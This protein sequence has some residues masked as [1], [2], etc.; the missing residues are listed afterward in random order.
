MKEKRS[1]L[2]P[3]VPIIIQFCKFR[4]GSE[5]N[6]RQKWP[7]SYPSQDHAKCHEVK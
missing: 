4:P 3:T 6:K 5:E 2:I 1:E 7:L